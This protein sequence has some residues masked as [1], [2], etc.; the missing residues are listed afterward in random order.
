M[1]NTSAGAD[2]STDAAALAKSSACRATPCCCGQRQPRLRRV[3]LRPGAAPSWPRCDRAARRRGHAA[4]GPTIAGVDYLAGRHRATRSTE[5]APRASLANLSALHAA[6]RGRG[7]RAVPAAA[8]SA[9]AASLDDDLVTIQRYAGKTNET[10]TH[11]LVNLALAASGDAFERWMAGERLRLLDPGLRPRHAPSTAP[12]STGSTRSGSSST[13][14]TWTAYDT[15]ITTWLQGQAAEAQRR[16]LH[17]A[18]GPPD[19]R[20]PDHDHLRHRRRT[21]RRTASIDV[22]HDDTRRARAT[23][24]RPGR[25]TS[26]W[27]TCPTACSTARAPTA[28]GARP[29]PRGACW[30]GAR[31][32][33]ASPASQGRGSALAWNRRT[34][35]RPRLVE[36]APRRGSRCRPP[37]DDRFVHRVDRS[38]TRDVLVAPP[39]AA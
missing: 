10:F 13:S 20:P 36:L 2:R 8:V 14:A 38:I 16:A 4:S 33:G 18:Q 5:R 9:D 1:S 34:L 22:V 29:R 21:C 3:G 11:L 24:P 12:R 26:S 37:D 27:A 17:A 15:F 35:P 23:T 31:P 19:P 39:S 28:G 32:R 25:S 30:R 7:R 6:V